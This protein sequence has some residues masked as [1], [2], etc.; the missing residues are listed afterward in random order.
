MRFLHKEDEQKE[1]TYEDAFLVP[2]YSKVRSRLDVDVTPPDKTGA[3]IPIAVSNMTSAA[4]KRMAE[5]VTRRGGLVVLT[6]DTPLERIEQIVKYLKTRHPVFE[7]PVM[8]DENESI[9]TALNLIYKRS[10]GGIVV[11]DKANKPVGIFTE[12]DAKNHDRFARLGDVMTTDIIS[13][14][15][16]IT[17]QEA[18]DK[19]HNSRVSIL[20]IIDSSEELVGVMTKKGAVRSTIY[21]SALNKQGEFIT[22][23]AM[24][25]SN[26]TKA[27]AEALMDMGVDIF[28]VDTAHGHTKRLV[29][30]TKAVRQTIGKD[31]ILYSGTVVTPKAVEALI[32]A[33]ADIVKVGIGSGASCTTRIMTGNGRP[34]L[35]AVIECAKV[36]RDMGAHI[37]ADGGIRHPRDLALA[38]AAGASSTMFAS[39]LVGTYESPGDIHEDEDGR[40]YKLNFGM[41]S[42]KAVKHRFKDKTP[43]DLAVK[44]YFEE[45][46][47]EGKIYVKEGMTG[48]EDIIDRLMSGLRSA[49]SYAGATTL[50]EF[51]ERAIIG[52]QTSAGFREGEA[53]LKH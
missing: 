38:M 24:G 30:A 32:N 31:K 41:A 39:I 35:S 37:W 22:A 7:T 27:R 26:G 29:D 9:Q 20:P 3:T 28:M 8:L 53:L 16:N 51:H 11:V 25:I 49:M 21:K 43:F 10:H 5:T 12:T 52:V 42:N 13:A 47:S 45:G 36:A 4:G 44:Q 18:F 33:G 40:L 23:V 19:I 48:V 50:Q 6:Q 34:Q 17:P 46:I 14:T 1:L 2:Q 15:E